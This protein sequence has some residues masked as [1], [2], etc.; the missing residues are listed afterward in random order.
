MVFPQV[1]AVVLAAFF[2]IFCWSLSASQPCGVSV[3]LRSCEILVDSSSDDPSSSFPSL[4]RMNH[5]P[6]RQRCHIGVR[7]RARISLFLTLFH[8]CVAHSRSHC[9]ILSAILAVS[10]ATFLFY[11]HLPP[12]VGRPGALRSWL[13]TPS[14]VQFFVSRRHLSTFL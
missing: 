1:C 10:P 13:H 12:F 7:T 5:K 2:L 8:T 9:R 11:S 6:Q 4:F 14:P 3:T